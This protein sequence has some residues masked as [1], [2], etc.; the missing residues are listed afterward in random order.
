[1]ATMVERL[2]QAWNS[3]DAAAVAALCAPDYV[4][5]QPVHPSRRFIGRGQVLANWTAVF[6]G[7]PD[8]RAELVASSMDGD[9]EWGEWNWTGRH[10][11]NSPFAMRGITIF[12]VRDGLIT[13]GRLYMEPVD[14]ADD[15]IAAAVQE[16]YRSPGSSA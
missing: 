2:A 6:E 14:P 4:S 3:H 7:V 5:D 12:L 13:G 15:D 1:M 16:L 8:F 11:D 9:T 10:T